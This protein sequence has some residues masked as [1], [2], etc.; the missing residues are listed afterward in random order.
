LYAVFDEE[1]YRKL[2]VHV[3]A[4]AVK[5]YERLAQQTPRHEGR[6]SAQVY[7]A[8]MYRTAESLLLNHENHQLELWCAWLRVDPN[9]VRRMYAAT[10]AVGRRSGHSHAKPDA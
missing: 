10:F 2:A 5:D 1:G 9:R 4:R 7:D 6:P 3:L 8:R